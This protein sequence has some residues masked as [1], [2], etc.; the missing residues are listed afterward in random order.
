MIYIYKREDG[1]VFEYQQRMSEDALTTCP[2]TGQAVCRV[3]TGGKGVHFSGYWPGKEADSQARHERGLAKDPLYTTLSDYKPKV[4]EF[5]E[6]HER[7]VTRKT[8]IAT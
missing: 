2:S 7:N 1:S 3:I 8:M 5:N 4:D 6:T